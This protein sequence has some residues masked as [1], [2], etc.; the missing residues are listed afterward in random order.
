MQGSNIFP[1]FDKVL[2]RGKKEELLKQR[3]IVIWMTGLSGSGKTTLAIG[4]EKYLNDEGH[5]TYLL[6]GDNIR[7]GINKDLGF[8]E[9][10]RVENIRRI[11]E[12]S[13]L[14]ANG[15][16][17]TINSFVSPSEELRELAKAIIGEKDFN[18]IYINTPLAECEKRD[19]KG[20]YAKARKGE[21]KDFTGISA[22]FDVPVSPALEIDT[23]NHSYE[24]C[25]QKLIEFVVP[26]IK[27]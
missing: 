5:L 13:K 2:D 22:P 14:F 9:K 12:I 24:E 27:L 8:S 11:A 4:L 16:I 3:G 7:S 23:H 15:G 17:V 25:L 6:D 18:C 1:I 21:I 19:T 20:L 26:K 10:D